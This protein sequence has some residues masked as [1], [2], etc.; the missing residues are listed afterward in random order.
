MRHTLFGLMTAL[1]LLSPLSASA[2]STDEAPFTAIVERA[3]WDRSV[4]IWKSVFSYTGKLRTT[5]WVFESVRQ[6]EG[7]YPEMPRWPRMN[8]YPGNNEEGRNRTMTHGMTVRNAET[9]ET[10][11]LFLAPKTWAKLAAQGEFEAMVTPDGR[12]IATE[13]RVGSSCP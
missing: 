7:E 11:T 10:S 3:F 8:T 13:C 5:R 6:T 2:Q 9:G 4:E 12:T 1:S